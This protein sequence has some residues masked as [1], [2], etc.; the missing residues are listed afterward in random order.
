MDNDGYVFCMNDEIMDYVQMAELMNQ[1]PSQ[2]QSSRVVTIQSELCA[3]DL[4]KDVLKIWQFATNI[5]PLWPFSSQ[6]ELLFCNSVRSRNRFV[7]EI[8]ALE[9]EYQF[10]YKEMH[11]GQDNNVVT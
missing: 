6:V 10:L 2:C 8:T 3:A 7:R 11:V 5:H 1:R 9:G 4:H